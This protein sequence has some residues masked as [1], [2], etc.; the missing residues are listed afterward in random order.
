MSIQVGGFP[1]RLIGLLNNEHCLIGFPF[2]LLFYHARTS[3]ASEWQYLCFKDCWQ[4]MRQFGEYVTACAVI[5]FTRTFSCICSLATS[6]C[7]F[8]YLWHVD[9]REKYRAFVSQW[10]CSFWDHLKR[11]QWKMCPV[12]RSH[13]CL[14]HQFKS[15]RPNTYQS[16][17]FL[18][19]LIV[20]LW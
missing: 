8:F 17:L 11:Y 3:G 9:E 13:I 15:P 7:A 6:K 4:F 5:F 19:F 14:K 10:N 20:F 18:C 12:G 16:H 2:T 1:V